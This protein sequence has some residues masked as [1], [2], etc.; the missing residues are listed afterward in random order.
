MRDVIFIQS[1]FPVQEQELNV[2]LNRWEGYG[3]ALSQLVSQ[4]SIKIIP[5][6]R[7]FLPI[8]HYE[9]LEFLSK[10]SGFFS[11]LRRARQ[12][13][14]T[15]G[16]GATL[17]CGDNQLS[18]LFAILLK[19]LLKR[20]ISIQT[21][22]HGDIYSSGVQ[23]GLKAT[24]RTLTSRIAMMSSNSIRVV[25]KFQEFEI[26]ELMPKISAEFVISPVP[27]DFS[28]IPVETEFTS[29][30]DV[31]FI[32]R[33]HYER[34]VDEA[35]SIMKELV[36]ARPT[37]KIVIVGSGPESNLVE[38]RLR[39]EISSGAVNLAGA[40][41]G[42]S[43]RNI[44]ARS[45]ILLSTAPREGYGLTLREAVLSGISV[46]ARKSLGA[47]EASINFPT[48]FHFYSS[49]N[50]AVE[51]VLAILESDDR[52]V[53]NSDLITFQQNADKDSINRLLASWVND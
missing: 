28:K 16:Q 8:N 43:L 32:G 12:K 7:K 5:L 33:L 4:G 27:I 46:V 45:K 36:L 29:G 24:I 18:L 3:F 49:E 40:L 22:F 25:S 41:Y 38:S 20:K 10:S 44:F 52:L 50:Q 26:K 30:F 39:E 6:D 21:Q 17:V 14:L 15:G 11:N 2:L 13:I 19:F 48:R 37:M 1:K 47:H 42:N 35:V 31:A 9:H 53:D 23:T 51:L 34:G